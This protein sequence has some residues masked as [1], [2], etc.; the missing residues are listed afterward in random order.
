VGKDNFQFS[1]VFI[2]SKELE[3]AIHTGNL[4]GFQMLFFRNTPSATAGLLLVVGRV[5]T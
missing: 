2:T 4:L 3:L 1:S 5:V